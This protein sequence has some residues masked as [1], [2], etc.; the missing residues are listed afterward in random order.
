MLYE[1]IKVQGNTIVLIPSDTLSSMGF[2]NLATTIGYLENIRKAVAKHQQ[3][4]RT[5]SNHIE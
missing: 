1:S 2:G 3:Q 5:Y 4:P